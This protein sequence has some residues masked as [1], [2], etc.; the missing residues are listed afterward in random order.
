M[1][2][3]LVGGIW[4]L[5][6]VLYFWFVCVGGWFGVRKCWRGGRWFLGCI[7]FFGLL[8]VMRC[9]LKLRVVWGGVVEFC[10]LE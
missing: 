9:L 10:Y 4:F 3:V 1:V 8:C 2:F 7:L 5:G 6:C